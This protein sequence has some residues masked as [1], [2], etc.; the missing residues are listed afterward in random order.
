MSR[1]RPWSSCPRDDIIS[2]L[3]VFMRL[4]EREHHGNSW[5]RYFF[6]WVIH[7]NLKVWDRSR[8]FP[9][10]ERNPST[11]IDSTFF[12]HLLKYPKHWLHI[13]LVHRAIRIICIYPSSDMVD[14]PIPL[15]RSF[16]CVCITLLNKFLYSKSLNIS[17]RFEVEFLLYFFLNRQTMTVPTP[18][19]LN[20]F[21]LH[22]VVSWHDILYDT[23]EQGTI[24]W[25]P[26]DKWRSI[27]KPIRF[28]FWPIIYRLLKGIILLPEF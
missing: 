8:E 24:V 6:I 20:A 16:F 25:H 22:R 23:R 3:Y 11:F 4:A 10:V 14:I 21:S 2:C 18:F 19:S 7:R 27:I 17:I 15:C 12:M 28:I 26:R 5:I 1:D 9:W 13:V